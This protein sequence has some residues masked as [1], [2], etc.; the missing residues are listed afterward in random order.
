LH[1]PS[2]FSQCSLNAISIFSLDG[3]AAGESQLGELLLQGL[4]LTPAQNQK[5]LLPAPAED[6][7]GV[8]QD[9]GEKVDER[10]T[11]EEESQVDLDEASDDVAAQVDS[12]PQGAQV[13]GDVVDDDQPNCLLFVL[14]MLL[15]CVVQVYLFSLHRDF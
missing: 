9:F 6:G 13:D 2:S 12:Q 10:Q 11:D 5:N 4:Q 15:F 7:D 1:F 3:D 14:L 8:Q